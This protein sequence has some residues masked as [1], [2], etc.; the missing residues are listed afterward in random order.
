MR[1]QLC[2]CD[3]F[4]HFSLQKL[5]LLDHN[6]SSREQRVR[7]MISHDDGP[8]RPKRVIVAVNQKAVSQFR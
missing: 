7:L 1:I 4:V 8:L 6:V 3:G 5:G 2:C